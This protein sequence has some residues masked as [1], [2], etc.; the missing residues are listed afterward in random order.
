MFLGMLFFRGFGGRLA[1]LKAF[2]DLGQK[3]SFI[4]TGASLDG[5]AGEES[6]SFNQRGRLC[7]LLPQFMAP[8]ICSC[9]GNDCS[10]A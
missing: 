3:D 5:F 10:A 2:K 6:R 7:K 9:N 4:D 8:G 1:I